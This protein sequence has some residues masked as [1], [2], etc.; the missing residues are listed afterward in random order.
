MPIDHRYLHVSH[1][2]TTSSY[3]Y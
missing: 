1:S 3:T 2:Q